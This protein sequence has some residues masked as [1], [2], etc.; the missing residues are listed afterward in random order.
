MRRHVSFHVVFPS[1]SA[2]DVASK[3]AGD[4]IRILDNVDCANNPRDSLLDSASYRYTRSHVLQHN[5]T[6]KDRD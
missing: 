5:V 1:D 2:S 6:A 4:G 3:T